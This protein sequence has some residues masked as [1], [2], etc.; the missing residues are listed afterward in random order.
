MA[1]HA[2]SAA[3]RTPDVL[4]FARLAT[5]P[6]EE[7]PFFTTRASKGIKAKE[8]VQRQEEESKDGKAKNEAAMKWNGKTMRK[9]GRNRDMTSTRR[10]QQAQARIGIA[11]RMIME[12]MRRPGRKRALKK[13]GVGGVPRPTKEEVANMAD[14]ENIGRMRNSSTQERIGQAG[15]A[16][17]I[18]VYTKH[19]GTGDTKVTTN[20]RR[21][22]KMRMIRTSGT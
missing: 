6:G 12:N 4:T 1:G 2:A 17:N 9:D 16:G 11:G 8:R 19:G 18:T 14:T 3:I 21:G 10:E 7:E 20:M 5:M 15:R 22:M 13:V